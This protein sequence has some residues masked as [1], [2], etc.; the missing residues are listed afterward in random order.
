[1]KFKN[2]LDKRKKIIVICFFVV[3][4]L[5]GIFIFSDYGMSWDEMICRNKG[6]SAK[7]YFLKGN[8]EAIDFEGKYYGATFEIFCYSFEKILGITD[9]ENI[10][11]I[12]LM[13]HFLTFVLFFTGVFF[14]YQICR[15][16]FRSW[17]Y[18]LT[19]A[20]FL[21]LTPRIFAHS[22]YNPKDIPFLSFFIIS[23]YTT[24][25]F[26]ERKDLKSAILN[27]AAC[28]ILIDIRI[29]GIMVPFTA[30]IFYI[31]DMIAGRKNC[32]DRGRILRNLF[33]Y[34]L[35]LLFFTVLLWPT[36][37]ENPLYHLGEAFKKMSSFP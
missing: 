11:E 24:M 34:G 4:F 18:G 33:V 9:Y 1:M 30:V 16:R 25:L 29:L 12:F 22:F 21:I 8:A 7:N 6:I 20:V 35:A 5:T 2:F 27:A 23:I 28:S 26:I 13:R 31:P 19:G 15:K 3:Y 37:W 10:R 14:F 17:K 36:L 32:P